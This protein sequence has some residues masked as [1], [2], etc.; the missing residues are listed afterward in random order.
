M[1]WS[2]EIERDRPWRIRAKLSASAAGRIRAPGREPV[3]DRGEADERDQPDDR[4]PGA[5]RLE[6]GP[7]DREQPEDRQ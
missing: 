5:A 4:P 2:G 1:M 3:A 7:P 6:H